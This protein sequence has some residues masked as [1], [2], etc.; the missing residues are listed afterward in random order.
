MAAIAASLAATLQAV[1]TE[2]VGYVTT[3][4]P[5]NSDGIVSPALHRAPVFSGKIASVDDADSVTLTGASFT[6]DQYAGGG[7]YLLVSSGDR[8]GMWAVIDSNDADTTNLTFVTEDL[9][10]QAGDKVLAGDSVS[11]IPFWTP[12]TLIPDGSAPE[13]T[14][15]LVF[16]RNEP[17]INLSASGTYTYFDGFGW[18]SGPTD[19]SDTPIYPDESVIV[20]N[21]SGSPINVVQSGNVPMS[22]FRTVLSHVST[23]VQQDIRL[24][25]GLP[26]PITLSELADP[27]AAGD[28]DQIL[29]FDSAQTGQ[30]KSASITATYFDGF[31][32]YSGPTDLNTHTINPGEGF[33]YRKAAS[34]SGDVVVDL[35]PSYQP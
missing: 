25:S 15:L 14:Q 7:Y 8:E 19:F 9:G 35:K 3:T 6:T 28:G 1:E 2:P 18:Y 34:N 16:S 31:G 23:G 5:A 21:V 12:S 30:N 27:G 17:G 20:R 10:S 4:V 13:N 32:W 33:I 29:I 22:A 11:I 24:T 26:S